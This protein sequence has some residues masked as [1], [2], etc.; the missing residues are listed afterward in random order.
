[1][2]AEAL[3]HGWFLL[4]YQPIVDLQ[5]RAVIGVEAL[6]RIQHPEQ[7]LLNPEYFIGQLEELDVADEI[8]AWVIT[9]ACRDWSTPDGKAKTALSVN[10]SGRLAAS[11]HLC[12]TVL[13]A[14]GDFPLNRLT[15]EM[16]ERVMIHA[17]PAV[18]RRHAAPVR[19][20]YAASPSTTSVPASR[21]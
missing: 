8:E 7:G 15:M 17:G 2:L 21:R 18:R 3:T 11:G 12:E 19:R 20:R 10:V 4:H 16:T 6:L 1:M 14:A 13:A 9:Q 5:S